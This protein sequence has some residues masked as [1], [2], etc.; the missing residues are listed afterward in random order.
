MSARVNSLNARGRASDG[1]R[2]ARSASIVTSDTPDFCAMSVWNA[3][4]Q[5]QS[6]SNAFASDST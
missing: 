3:T 6:F 1:D 4:H 2:P 5:S